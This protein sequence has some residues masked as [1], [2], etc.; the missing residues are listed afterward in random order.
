[1]RMSNHLA[2][3]PI[4]AWGWSSVL[5]DKPDELQ[6]INPFTVTE[7]STVIITKRC[8]GTLGSPKLRT[9]LDSANPYNPVP[10]K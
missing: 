7:I 1:M 10:D 8:F 9:G 5:D 6:Y 3:R 4:R 2:D